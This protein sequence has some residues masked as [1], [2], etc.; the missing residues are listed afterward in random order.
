MGE[1]GAGK[2]TLIKVLTGI[3]KP[4]NG[5]IFFNGQNANHNHDLFQAVGYVPQ[6]LEQSNNLT[7]ADN[8]FMPFEKT[9]FNSFILNKSEIFSQCEPWLKKFHITAK[10]NEL[11]KDISVSNQQLLQIACAMVNKKAKIL[12]LDEPTTSLTMENIETLFKLMKEI[13]QHGVAIIFISH[14]LEEVFSICD[15]IT[16]LRNGKKIVEG[17]TKNVD[18]SWAI[19][20]WWAMILM[21][22]RLISQNKYRMK[23]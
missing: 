20:T 13:R 21:Q 22:K 5:D 19:H 18:I 1:N 14:K 15:D 4:D 3:Y 10:P 6:E 7:V 2:S 11:V 16:V 23:W 17:K 12:L 8:L 9:G